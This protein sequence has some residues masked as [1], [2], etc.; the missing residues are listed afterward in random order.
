MNIKEIIG[1]IF[2]IAVKVVLVCMA[3]MFIMKYAKEAYEIGYRVFTES[4]VDTGKGR[5]ASITVGESTSTYEVGEKLV[6]AGLVRD[7]RVFFLQELASESHG[8]IKPGKYDLNTNMAAEEMIQIMAGTYE[9]EDNTDPLYNS[10]EEGS[11]GEGMV[12][13]SA[14][15]LFGDDGLVDAIDDSEDSG[16][17]TE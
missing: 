5:I 4:P 15:E 10:D 2:S 8:K 13:M 6:E 12:E 9:E 16:E 14:D 11:V 17:D 7:A 3:A 1:S